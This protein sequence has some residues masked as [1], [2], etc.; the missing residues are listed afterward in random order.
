M[1]T[2]P[3][4]RES[5][6]SLY[7]VLRYL[8]RNVPTINKA[9]DAPGDNLPRNGVDLA[10]IRVFVIEAVMLGARQSG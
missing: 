3:L 7:L 1:L 4:Y 2:G 8:D 5:H 6:F 10:D 9:L